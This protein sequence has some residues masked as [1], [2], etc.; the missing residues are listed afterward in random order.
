[1]RLVICICLIAFFNVSIITV[2]AEQLKNDKA[3]F[4]NRNMNNKEFFKNYQLKIDVES[5]KEL[6]LSGNALNSFVDCATTL[7]NLE[8]LDLSRNCLDKFYF[9]CKDESY[10]LRFLNVSHNQLEYIDERALNHRTSKLKVLDV[11]WNFLNGLNDTMFQH[12]EVLEHLS[13]S[14]N[15]IGENMDDFVFENLTTLMYLDLKNISVS[16]FY[17]KIFE[18]LI[19]LVH[20]D[21]SWNPIEAIP[22]LPVNLEI[23]DLSQTNIY[24]LG[25]LELPRLRELRL[26]SMHNLS[27]VN[28]NDFEK[29]RNLSLLSMRNSKKLK[30]LIMWQPKPHLLPKLRYLDIEYCAL[31]NLSSELRSTI[32]GTTVFTFQNNPWNCDCKMKWILQ[33]NS[34]HNLRSKIVC[35]SPVLVQNK[36]IS[37]IPV[38]ELRCN[39]DMYNFTPILWIFIISVSLCLIIVSIILLFRK[40]LTNWIIRR[41]RSG[42]SVSYTNVVESSNDLVKILNDSDLQDRLEECIKP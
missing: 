29:L 18:N 5:L 14:H 23:L 16:F 33:F 15:P 38:D 24:R 21:L 40:S 37:E 10:D 9:L 6:N 20:L 41:R 13:L 2:L 31:E 12:M 34:T 8:V 4:S 35:T 1:M 19:N 27:S 11:S 25:P 17:P 28:L 32:E 3:D 22:V 39:T 26:E 30:H 36:P 42:D 7:H